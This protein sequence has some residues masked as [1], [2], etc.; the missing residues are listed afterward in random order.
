[1]R[2]FSFFKIV[3]TYVLFPKEQENE[4]RSSDESQFIA[5]WKRKPNMANI[6][7]QHCE[8]RAR[9]RG[10]KTERKKENNL[11]LVSRLSGLIGKIK[12]PRLPTPGIHVACKTE[13][14]DGSSSKKRLH[15][16]SRTHS[17]SFHSR[18]KFSSIWYVPS[19]LNNHLL[20]H[21]PP[22]ES[23]QSS[24]SLSPTEHKAEP[25]WCLILSKLHLKPAGI[26][27]RDKDCCNV[28]KSIRISYS[29]IAE[30]TLQHN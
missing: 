23:P 17:Y 6:L 25:H 28:L 2:V 29:H 1:M 16:K 22:E 20:W 10:R 8:K 30:I 24:S 9:V 15:F 11:D 18:P 26:N 3:C 13:T 21:F 5:K 12:Q 4:R 27:T 14:F 19:S 7:P